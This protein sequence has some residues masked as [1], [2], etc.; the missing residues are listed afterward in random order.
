MVSVMKKKENK[1]KC[2]EEL[3]RKCGKLTKR[4]VL[5]RKAI[6]KGKL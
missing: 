2:G 6:K 4:K 5:S 3:K 1:K